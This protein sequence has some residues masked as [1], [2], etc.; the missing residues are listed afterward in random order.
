M[1]EYSRFLTWDRRCIDRG[2]YGMPAGDSFYL[3]LTDYNQPYPCPNGLGIDDRPVQELEWYR[4][5]L[6]KAK[7]FISEWNI[8]I[9]LH[10]VAESI[11]DEEIF[12]EI[13]VIRQWQHSQKQA[14]QQTGSHALMQVEAS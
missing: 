1:S 2:S 6:E 11:T 3:G 8:E 10:D 5:R 13:E 9:R 7:R 12:L 14:Q 4:N